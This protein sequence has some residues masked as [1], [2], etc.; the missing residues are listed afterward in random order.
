MNLVR[1]LLLIA[2]LLAPAAQAQPNLA[3]LA[4]QGKQ[5]MGEGRFAEA[6]KLYGQIV[7]EIPDNPGLWLN[8]GMALHM[9][10]QDQQ[11]LA[12]LE[13]AL[14]IEPQMFPAQLFLG[15]S[16]LRLGKPTEAIGPLEK[17]VR[18]QPKDPQIQNM[19]ADA[20]TQLGR[21]RA[22]LPHRVQVTQLEP[23]N[24]GAWAGLI[25][26]YEELAGADFQ[27]LEHKAP[28]SPWMLRL[29]AD[30][31]L[32]Q[33]QYPSAFYLYQQ[34]LERAPEMRGLHAGLSEI[35][36]RTDRAD[37]AAIEKAR[38]AEAPDPDCAQARLEC[39]VSAGELQ[40]AVMAEAA[41]PRDYFWRARAASLLGQQA[42]LKLAALPDSARKY[43][44]LASIQA[45]QGRSADSADAWKKALELDPGN[46]LYAGELA[47]RLY[48]AGRFDEA[49]PRLEA[50]HKKYPGE[51]RWSFLL[52][53]VYLQQQDVERAIP[54]LEQAVKQGPKLLPARHALGR[55][56]M[57]IGDAEKAIPQ[58]K[59]ALSV[60]TDG[61]LH[62]QLAQAYIRTDRR[63]DAA[64]PLAKYRE[65]QQT[66]QAQIEA[67]QQMEITAPAP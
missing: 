44:L 56:Y 50:L 9:S 24:P 31:R 3:A 21:L 20:Y 66:Q 11:A 42:F 59:A 23:G 13:K 63:A 28:E 26:T 46:E 60:D 39:A 57:Q 14:S 18:L 7:G 65:L 45:S 58:L 48:F 49:L 30:M 61:S 38:E 62:Y 19:L 54:L 5:A 15:A 37:W 34:A 35:Y 64:A 51:S 43:E 2:F 55:A 17:A 40:R 29:V 27:A 8:L 4:Q 1:V 6:A 33:Q 22:A 53:D 47:T 67:A 52:G 36:A 10:G 12:P 25:Q 16:L 41:T 32:A